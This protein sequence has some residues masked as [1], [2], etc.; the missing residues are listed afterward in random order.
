MKLDHQRLGGNVWHR[1]EDLE[2]IRVLSDRVPQ[3][4]MRVFLFTDDMGVRGMQN[5][6]RAAVVVDLERAG[7]GMIKSDE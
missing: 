7:F 4:L 6:V 1:I 2:Y 3:G 5:D